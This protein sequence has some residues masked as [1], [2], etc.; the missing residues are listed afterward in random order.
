MILENKYVNNKFSS[1]MRLI[2][3]S[4]NA[5]FFKNL[6]LKNVKIRLLI[7]ANNKFYF[8]INKFI[9]AWSNMFN[10]KAYSYRRRILR[11]NPCSSY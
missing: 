4:F 5:I 8:V 7:N 10:D 11:R 1:F 6:C 3:K 9:L 2:K